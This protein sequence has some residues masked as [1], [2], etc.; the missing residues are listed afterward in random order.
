MPDAATQRRHVTG[1][2]RLLIA[3][4]LICLTALGLILGADVRTV[5]ITGPLLSIVGLITTVVAHRAR[6]R[7]AVFIGAAHCA[8]CVLF[9]ALVNLFQWSPDR[10]V[11]PFEVMGTVFTAAVGAATWFALRHPPRF[12]EPWT[13]IG[14]GYLLYGLTEA[15]CPECGRPFEPA[16]FDG[17][18]PPEGAVGVEPG[19]QRG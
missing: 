17:R 6:Y 13:C 3:D 12:V 4:L 10:A 16:M 7:T 19:R 8:I 11:R 14:C 15:R 5:L 18:P 9:V 1:T 2:V